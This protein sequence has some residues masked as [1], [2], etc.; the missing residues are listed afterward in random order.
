[1]DLMCRVLHVSRSG[2][3]AWSGRAPSQQERRREELGRH[4]LEAHRGS[5]ETYGSP[6]IHRQLVA[7]GIDCAENTVAKLMRDAGIRSKA[8]KRFKPTTTDSRHRQPIAA[9][10]LNREFQV[11]EPDKVW[12]SD[13][14][15]IPTAEGWLYLAV[16]MDLC[17]R[18]IVG[19][20]TADHLRAELATSA[21]C[22]ALAHRRPS[23]GV[24][25]HSDRGVQYASE[26]YRQLLARH[27][28]EASMSGV[29]DCYDNAVVESFF[30]TLKRELTH[31]TTYRSH[32]EANRSLFEYIEVFYNRRRLHSTLGY[33]SPVEFEKSLP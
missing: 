22:M 20:A 12:A 7:G 29:G 8:Q 1:M 11:D 2:F 26:S 32:E 21:L 18:R 5:G 23:R 13:I 17:T 14:T 30:S 33:R 24:L 10:T 4:I 9:N 25:H 15:Y 16:V 28:I 19:W 6:R 31:H 3:Y 27:R